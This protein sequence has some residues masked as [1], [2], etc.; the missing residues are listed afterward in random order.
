MLVA[1]TIIAVALAAASRAANLGT[2][3]A[4]LLRTRS[5]ALWVA[6]N[7]VALAQLQQPWP[8]SGERSGQAPQGG[9]VFAWR[10]TVTTT[11]NPELRKIDVSVSLPESPEYVQARLTAFLPRISAR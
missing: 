3:G 9:L 1:L 6:Q 4:E 2:E 8:E 5:L 10:E 7:R 11:P